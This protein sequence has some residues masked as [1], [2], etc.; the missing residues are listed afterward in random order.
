MSTEVVDKMLRPQFNNPKNYED[1][2]YRLQFGKESKVFFADRKKI[3]NLKFLILPRFGSNKFSTT[4]FS[5]VILW[6]FYSR[7]FI[8]EENLNSDL[9]TS[10]P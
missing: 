7:S 8:T 1:Q 5:V 6:K 4:E 9:Q 2:Y 3:R 10:W